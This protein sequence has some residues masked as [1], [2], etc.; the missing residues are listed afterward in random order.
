MT[1]ALKP[2]ADLEQRPTEL[3]QTGLGGAVCAKTTTGFGPTLTQ[4][5]GR[6]DRELSDEEFWDMIRARATD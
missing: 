5:N 6:P 1:V 2:L 3:V 4:P